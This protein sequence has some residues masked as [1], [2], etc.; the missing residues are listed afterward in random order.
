MKLYDEIIKEWEELLGEIAVGSKTGEA[1]QALSLE[2]ANWP[3]VDDRSMILRSDMAY[4]L[5]SGNLPGI[6]LT[7]I[8]DSQ[9]LLP[10]DGLFLVGD[11]LPDIS[12]DNSFGR[13]TVLRVEPGLLKEGDALYKAI[14]NLEYTRY[15]FYPEGFMMRVSASKSKENVRI[16]KDAL[17]KGL[18]FEKTGRQMMD[19]FKSHKGVQA[20]SMTYI[21]APDFPF[22]KLMNLQKKAEAIT[23]AI[24]HIGAGAIMDCNACNLQPVCDEVEG[25]RELQ[26]SH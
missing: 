21:T 14:R 23:K 19:A 4:E 26:F 6:G 2:G 15:H 22:E 11:D 13:V 9:E 3:T 10:E 7:L 16:S 5:G 25:L 1:V 17:K 24:D 20:V 8:T 12:K 18:T